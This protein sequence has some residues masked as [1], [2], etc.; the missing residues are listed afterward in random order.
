MARPST[1]DPEMINYAM[2]SPVNTDIEMLDV[3]KLAPESP[4]HFVSQTQEFLNTPSFNINGQIS[5]LS[6]DDLSWLAI[7]E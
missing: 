3:S 2:L 5:N 7:F 1:E 6:E 4:L